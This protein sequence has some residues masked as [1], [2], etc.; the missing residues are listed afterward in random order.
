MCDIP[1]VIYMRD[2]GDDGIELTSEKGYGA[3][4]YIR[5]DLLEKAESERDALEIDLKN[6]QTEMVDYAERADAL[7]AHVELLT[8]E[9]EKNDQYPSLW[10]V[11]KQSP[12]TSLTRLKARWQAEELARWT[13]GSQIMPISLNLAMQDRRKAL[14]RAWLEGDW[15]KA[16]ANEIEAGD[17]HD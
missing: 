16:R 4:K 10:R 1:E 8:E 17:D 13:H 7:A 15:D 2:D 12:E 9:C 14:E 3:T 6:A 5:A 11:V